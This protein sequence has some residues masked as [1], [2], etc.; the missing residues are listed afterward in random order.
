[1]EF[2]EIVNAAFAEEI[3]RLESLKAQNRLTEFGECS[4]ITLRSLKST[5]DYRVEAQAEA[6]SK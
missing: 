5:I 6:A 4:L 1:V 3:Q 2:Q